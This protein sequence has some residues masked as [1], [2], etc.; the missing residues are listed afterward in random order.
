MRTEEQFVDMI[1][2]ALA[3]THGDQTPD[4]F[5]DLIPYIR[6]AYPEA[7]QI[8]PEEL[9]HFV[10]GDES[11]LVDWRCKKYPRL[12]EIFTNSY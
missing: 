7:G 4:D 1:L 2:H 12:E 6:A 9:A 3:E 11:W 10:M 8:T 5:V